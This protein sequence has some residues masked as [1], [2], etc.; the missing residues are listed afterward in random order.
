MLDFSSKYLEIIPNTTRWILAPN[1]L[2][3]FQTPLVKSPK[4]ALTLLL[5]RK[6]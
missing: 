3:L 4:R 2:K 1:I 6:Q 5:K